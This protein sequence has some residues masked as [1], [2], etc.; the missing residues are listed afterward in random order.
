M[1]KIDKKKVIHHAIEVLGESGWHTDDLARNVND[2]IVDPH[3]ED[4][5]SFCVLGATWKSLYDLYGI[6]ISDF[7]D[8]DDMPDN[9]YGDIQEV[10]LKLN[11]NDALPTEHLND[12]EFED[13][14]DAIEFLKA[15][16]KVIN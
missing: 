16:E 5:V 7:S 10:A 9:L 12:N 11:P 15:V 14:E 8:Y 13:K 6:L 2:D 3:N 4:A 1:E